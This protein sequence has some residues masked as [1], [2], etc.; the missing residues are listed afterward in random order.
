MNIMRAFAENH[1]HPR[2]LLG[3]LVGFRLARV[4]REP[5]DWT[6]S[7]LDLQPTDHVLEVGFGPGLGVQQAAAIVS[8]GRVAGV[9][10]SEAMLKMAS[11]RNAAGIAAGRVHLE[12][13]ELA[14]L[15]YASDSF[16]KAFAVQVI[17]F[18][19]NPV[20]DLT[21]LCRVMKPGGRVALFME[22]Q[23]KLARSGALLDG[24]YTLY[25]PEEVVRFLEE[26]GFA[27]AWFETRA[28]KFS[29]GIC[30]LAEKGNPGSI[31]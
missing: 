18:L 17:Y 5:N 28:L 21:E 23:E 10:P 6:L 12:K 3:R 27:R 7:L 1:A 8:A 11:K 26:A 31:E 22:A 24:I 4:N 2:G 14:A 29:P 30:I 25:T 13:G 16:D 19:A 9:D 20:A 15:P